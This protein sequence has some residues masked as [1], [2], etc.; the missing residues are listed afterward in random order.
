MAYVYVRGLLTVKAVDWE[1]PSTPTEGGNYIHLL[2]QLRE[3][4]P[5]PEYVLASCLPAG[6]WALRNVDLG[7]AA[8]YLDFLNIM[9]YDFSGPW[10]NTTGHHAQLHS[11]S[12][13]PTSAQ[14][15]TSYVLNQ[16][17]HRKKLLLGI[18]AYGRSFLGSSKPG[19]SYAGC[20]GEDGVFDYKDLPRPGAKEGV[21]EKV[22]AAFCVGGDGGF[23][24]YD[25]TRTVQQK[26]KFVV[27]EGLGGLF[28][29]QIAADAQ[30]PRS[31][32]EMGYNTLHDM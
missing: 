27:K 21:D 10:T 28:Y 12:K 32:V 8:R 2:S 6:E 18:P 30:G 13:S 9:A 31:L 29:W 1:H 20:G 7:K 11:S 25:S 24:S 22:G 23:V 15:A 16:G 3:A 5:S 26:A 19:Q 14:S 4:F 17:V